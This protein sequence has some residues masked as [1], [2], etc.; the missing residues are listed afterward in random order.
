MAWNHSIFGRFRFVCRL[1]SFGSPKRYRSS[2]NTW[3]PST[4]EC[5]KS[6]N[7][8]ASITLQFYHRTLPTN[9]LVSTKFC[10]INHRDVLFR[11]SIW[12]NSLW[13]RWANQNI[14]AK[15]VASLRLLRRNSVGFLNSNF[16]GNKSNEI[17]FNLFTIFYIYNLL[18]SSKNSMHENKT[19][20]LH[21]FFS[22]LCDMIYGMYL[23]VLISE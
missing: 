6:R 20:C 16:M 1:S 2:L 13:T 12:L 4:S 10:T 5:S 14:L 7:N 3:T 19:M 11:S 18:K 15:C 21:E 17:L 8:L 23:F 22:I 9:H